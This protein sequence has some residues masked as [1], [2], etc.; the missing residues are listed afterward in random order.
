MDKEKERGLVFP[1]AH[2]RLQK[3]YEIL[4]ENNWGGRGKTIPSEKEKIGSDS[5]TGRR[6]LTPHFSGRQPFSIRRK[7]DVK[8]KKKQFT[9]EP[10]RC[11]SP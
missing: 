8:K 5:F 6:D 10:R 4:K 11:K 1:N 7:R 2:F 9:R 3:A